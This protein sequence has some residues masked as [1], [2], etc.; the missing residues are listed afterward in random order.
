M[1]TVLEIIKRTTEFF[2]KRGV[3]S[4]RL[5]A[6]LLI[7]HA[8]ALKRM[9]LYL[10]FERPL[11][12]AELEKIRPLVKRRGNREP[13]QYIIGDT[14]FCG[15]KL[16]VDRRALIPR[17]E[18]EYLVELITGR[19]TAPPER[20][21]DL[22]TGTGAL[23]L[24][25]ATHYPAALV[26]AVD[27]SADALALAG[28]NAAALNLAG[29]VALVASDWFSAVPPTD[30]FALIVAN[31]PYLTA[32]EVAEAAPEVREHEPHAALVAA[33]D[34]CADLE[35]IIRQART[36]LAP[37]GMLACET[38]IAQHAR[39]RALAETAGYARTESLPDLTGRDRFLLAFV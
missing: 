26:T 9:Q 20:I 13:L 28:E 18:T 35:V 16:K 3:E 4:A 14:E 11:A 25:L 36:Y 31:P 22:G 37:G 12:E 38:G 15:L 24:A 34:G 7:G 39:L 2:D 23:A 17:P 5:N 10:Q 27:A 1:L 30:R 6:E 33:A 32:A 19:V 29:R 8:L 21:L